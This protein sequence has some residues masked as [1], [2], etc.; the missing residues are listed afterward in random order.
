ME[1]QENKI[2]KTLQG[3]FWMILATGGVLAFLVMANQL[4]SFVQK[5]FPRQFASLD[6]AKHSIGLDTVL[7]PAYFPEGISWPPSFIFAQKRPY[8]VL[9]MEFKDTLGATTLIVVQS[10]MPGSVTQFQRI[11]LTVVKQET[12][13]GLKGKNALLQIG[14]CDNTMPC[15]QIAWQDKGDSCTVLLMSSPFEVIKI[16]ESMIH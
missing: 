3:L 6:E 8:K 7:V 14:T 4:P 11:R 2:V 12:E 1:N 16:A 5:D 13:Y 10:S 9:V 15:S